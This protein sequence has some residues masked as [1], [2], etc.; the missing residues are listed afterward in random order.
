[1]N[2][3]AQ[4]EERVESKELKMESSEIGPISQLDLFAVS[5]LTLLVYQA[6]TFGNDALVTTE[7]STG[8]TDGLDYTGLSGTGSYSSSCPC[9]Q[10]STARSC[11]ESM[12]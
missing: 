7:S 8:T 11:K 1:M 6:Y 12:H 10:W 3:L 5:L 9:I 2:D 4:L